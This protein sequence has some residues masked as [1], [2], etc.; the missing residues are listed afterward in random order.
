[1]SGKLVCTRKTDCTVIIIGYDLSNLHYATSVHTVA[2]NEKLNTE[3]ILHFLSY[4]MCAFKPM[5]FL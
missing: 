5:L 1:M 3:S 2:V 4:D